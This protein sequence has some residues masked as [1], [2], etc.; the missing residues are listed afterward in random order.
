[1]SREPRWYQAIIGPEGKDVPEHEL[2]PFHLH[3]ATTKQ[4][5][6][7][8]EL[9]REWGF[10]DLRDYRAFMREVGLDYYDLIKMASPD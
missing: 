8:R 5:G 2:L 1:M 6:A 3:K 10:K 9:A 7:M 4:T